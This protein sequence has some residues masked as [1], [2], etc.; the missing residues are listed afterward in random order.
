MINISKL[1]GVFAYLKNNKVISA[2]SL[3]MRGFSEKDIKLMVSNGTF[4]VEG[5]NYS[6]NSLKKM[7]EYGILY[8]NNN[9]TKEAK[10]CFKSCILVDSSFSEA[11]Y[12]LFLI[13]LK[14]NVYEVAFKYYEGFCNDSRFRVQAKIL[15]Y[16]ISKLTNIPSIYQGNISKEDIFNIESNEEIKY[17]ICVQN[18]ESLFV[19]ISRYVQSYGNSNYSNKILTTLINRVKKR[20]KRR[21]NR[22]LDFVL[23]KQYNE[24]IKYLEVSTEGK[25]NKFETYVLKLVKVI[26]SNNC[27]YTN[28]NGSDIFE[29]IDLCNYKLAL[30]MSI[31]RNENNELNEETNVIN[32]LLK[33]I[34]EN[35]GLINKKEVSEIPKDND[36][37]S[38]VVNLVYKNGLFLIYKDSEL[39]SKLDEILERSPN[40]KVF[41]ADDYVALKYSLVSVKSF[42]YNMLL[43]EGEKTYRN[44]NFYASLKC[45]RK[46]FFTD[47][48]NYFVLARLGL[49]YLKL[50]KYDIAADYL[51]VVTDLSLK[52]GGNFDFTEILEIIDFSKTNIGDVK[53]PVK[54]KVSDF[55]NDIDIL[56]GFNKKCVDL[57]LKGQSYNEVTSGLCTNDKQMIFLELARI[58]YNMGEYDKGDKVLRE[59]EKCK[60]KTKEVIDLLNEARTN[61]LFYKYRGR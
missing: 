45:Y 19:A 32:I 44:N 41:Y 24:L 42:D 20:N 43:R 11:Y 6:I 2:K 5:N 57:I 54:M 46:L 8:L 56:R 39:Y 50:G 18:C 15:V 29:A 25:M 60:P 40:L 16:L 28:Q 36:E 7:Y 14:N 61:K 3:E 27:Y 58:Y 10:E 1:R 53:T 9:N 49:I 31:K 51:R 35:L 48:C 22:I 13:C 52:Y 23:N 30:D 34:N 4:K 12:M 26:S 33:R 37:L 59:V 38:E 17:F 47:N 21:R 55:G